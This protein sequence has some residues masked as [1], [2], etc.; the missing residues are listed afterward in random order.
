[1]NII[2]QLLR[3]A[4]NNAEREAEAEKE[5]VES[6]QAHFGYLFD[7]YEGLAHLE[8]LEMLSNQSETK[9]Q[10]FLTTM[11]PQMLQE[12]KPQLI[13]VKEAFEISDLDDDD[14]SK[15]ELGWVS[16]VIRDF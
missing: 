9:V 7:E 14:E 5:F 13:S 10:A 3:E 11:K 6:S 12:L 15:F 1:L 4:K 2:F 16:Q 8:A